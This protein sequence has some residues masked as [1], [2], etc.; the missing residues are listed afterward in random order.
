MLCGTFVTPRKFRRGISARTDQFR[1]LHLPPQSSFRATAQS[2]P[3]AGGRCDCCAARQPTRPRGCGHSR[4]HPTGTVSSRSH[5]VGQPLQRR[6]AN[7]G[8]SSSQ[9]RDTGKP[10][11]RS[12]SQPNYRPTDWRFISPGSPPRASSDRARESKRLSQWPPPSS[13][14]RNR[15]ARRRTRLPVRRTAPWSIPRR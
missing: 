14:T 1:R 10:T 2:R 12:R 7:Y 8:P 9:F 11:N 13:R 5:H 15:T 3:V 6:A 4:A